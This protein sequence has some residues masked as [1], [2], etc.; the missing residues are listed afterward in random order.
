MK[1]T[2][3]RK[4]LLNQRVFRRLAFLICLSGAFFF[5]AAQCNPPSGLAVTNITPSSIDFS[6]NA[7]AGA[8]GYEYVVTNTSAFPSSGIFTTATSV[9]I[10]FAYYQDSTRYI[11][12]RSKCGASYSSWL[13]ICKAN[14]NTL[15]GSGRFCDG[16]ILNIGI[17]L[18]IEGQTY[19]WL[20]DG[21]TV[22]GSGSPADGDG[23]N[24][25]YYPPMS[26]ARV[27]TYNVITTAP[28]CQSTTF[29]SVT[30]GSKAPVSNLT[31]T[32]VSF[33][34][35]RFTWSG[36]SPSFYC[37]VYGGSNYNDITVTDTSA[38]FGS[39]IPGTNYTIEV[40]S[41]SCDGLGLSASIN[42]N[43][44]YAACP[45]GFAV[46]KVYNG[47]TGF[48]YAWQVQTPGSNSFINLANGGSYSGVN[49]NLLNISN[50]PT[51]FTGNRYR[52]I[53]SYLGNVYSTSIPMGL[54]FVETWTGYSNTAWQN[55]SNW[56]CVVVPDANTDIL[57]PGDAVI[58]PVINTNQSC[59]SLSVQ[60]GATLTITSGVNLNVTGN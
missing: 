51:S 60:P 44:D 45:S 9:S 29:G 22:T 20:Q 5:C 43:T 35:V 57:I 36:K 18:T 12:V 23:G 2:T 24:K 11:Y 54:R 26:A 16:E 25:S 50:P 6:W 46:F 27:G 55:A 19:T 41:D 47:G 48:T 53:S 30:I 8:S 34:S 31:T 56:N 7:V 21:F 49:S 33:D 38:S 39:L 10:N 14:P 15:G 59:K 58:M 52:C 3:C 4:F 40:I 1:M 37:Q 17:P 32:Y 13:A 42:F 28:G